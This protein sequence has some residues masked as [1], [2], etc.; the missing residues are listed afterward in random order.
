M[1]KSG[2]AVTIC[3]GGN[4]AHAFAGLASLVDGAHVT[5]LDV[6]EDETE[7][8]NI[9][10]AKNGFKVTYTN[11]QSVGFKPDNLRFSVTRDV[12][13]AAD[14]DLVVLVVPAYA[15]ELYLNL[16]IP[17]L[18]PDAVV[19]GMPGHA[20]FEYQ[21]GSIL[22]K[23]DKKNAIVCLETLPWACRY[24]KYGEEAGIVGT[25][26]ETV[27]SYVQ[28]KGGQ[29]PFSEPLPVLQ[30]LVGPKP[31][32]KL[33]E[34]YV[35][36]TLM[37]K[38]TIHPPI[39]YARWKDWQGTPLTQR[40]L[41]YQGVDEKAAQYLDGLNEEILSTAAQLSKKFPSMDF[42][43]IPS[44]QEWF[45][46]HYGDQISDQSTLVACMRTN[47]GYAGLTHPM[48]SKDGG[49]VP[50]FTYRYT[51]ED[52]PYGLLVLKQIADMAGVETPVISEI[53]E[54]AQTKIGK[55]FLED[56]RLCDVGREDARLPE[57]YGIN[58]L[59]ELVNFFE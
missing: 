4:G 58:T 14:A 7:R 20:G 51:T 44:F 46:H 29:K 30:K 41:F 53:I 49:F 9:A 16:V 40:P 25:K 56:G 34:N 57:A 27:C 15:H 43:G 32:L 5:V 45:I 28:F 19:V 54:W 17:H 26:D 18:K 12:S 21:S 6:Y 10:M 1:S 50:D 47:S 38:S 11:G 48:M 8:W 13:V 35:K 59:D 33:C 39:M 23:F 3:G 24:I 37:T 36:C 31:V 52:I 42:T 55:R 22:K 2:V